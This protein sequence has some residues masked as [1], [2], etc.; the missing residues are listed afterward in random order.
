M[1]LS[2]TQRR[3]FKSSCGQN[4]TVTFKQTAMHYKQR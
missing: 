4:M 2:R 1:D 3:F